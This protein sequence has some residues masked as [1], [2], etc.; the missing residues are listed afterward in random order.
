M[1]VN[2]LLPRLE[3][4]MRVLFDAAATEG[5]VVGARS[6]I[7]EVAAELH[8]TADA[9]RNF[10]SRDQFRL[11]NDGAMVFDKFAEGFDVA[12]N[13]TN[14]HLIEPIINAWAGATL[15]DVRHAV[16]VDAEGMV[17]LDA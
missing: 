14:R 10:F 9:G 15:H 5:A 11:I 17:H 1:V 12:S 3:G 6:T 8:A 7:G 2:Q 16:N 13:V 4:A